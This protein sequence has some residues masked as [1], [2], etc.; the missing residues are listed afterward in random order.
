MRYTMPKSS[1]ILFTNHIGWACHVV[2][3]NLA[4]L[5][6]YII[7]AIPAT[8]AI[9][10]TPKS[11]HTRIRCLRGILIFQKIER[12]SRTTRRSVIVFKTLQTSKFSASSRHFLSRIV[13]SQNA[14]MGLVSSCQHVEDGSN[15]KDTDLH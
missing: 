4:T 10:P 1:S 15:T 11:A 7:R 8:Q 2:S 9:P 14:L 12:G 5:S 6:V 3:R 13:R